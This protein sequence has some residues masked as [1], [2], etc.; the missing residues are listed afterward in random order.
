MRKTPHTRLKKSAFELHYG[1]ESNTK[2]IYMLNLDALK[3][4]TKYCISAQPDTLHVYSF[5]GAGGASDQLPMKQKKGAK[6]VSNYSFLFLDKKINKPKCDSAYSDKTQ[7]AVLGT[8]HTI[9]TSDNKTLHRKH[10]CKPVSE[11]VQENNN[12]GTGP[13]RPDGRFTKSTRITNIQ[14]SD[15]DTG[16]AP[17][18]THTTTTPTFGESTTPPLK[19]GTI[20]RGRPKLVRNRQNS[21]S[22]RRPSTHSDN[23]HFGKKP[24]Y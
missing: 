11:G 3:T 24:Q 22:P 21:G 14:D 18:V 2:I 17:L 12:R 1:R 13:G 9:T 8:K 19:S 16:D 10:I 20:G 23:Q 7:I 6:G 5:S 4:I 15:S